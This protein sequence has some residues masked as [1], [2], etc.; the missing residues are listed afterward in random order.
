MP[1]AS[2]AARPAEPDSR[3]VWLSILGFWSFYFLVNSARGAVLAHHHQLAMLLPRVI[4]TVLSMAITAVFYLALR[5][6]SAASIRRSIVA[7][8][9]LAAPAAL[10]YSTVNWLVFDQQIRHEHAAGHSRPPRPVS[11]AGGEDSA[12]EAG[13]E[14][15]ESLEVGRMT[16]PPHLT[17]FQGIADQAVNGY[18][19]FVAWA[20]LHLALRYASEVRTLERRSADLRA[21]A[22]SAELRALRYQV[23]PHFLF[24]TLNSLSSLVLTD[25]R[26]R[27]ERMILNLS[28]FFRHSL[29]GD[30]TEDVT[31][32]EEI[33]LQRL[34]LD[35]EAVRFPER[36]RVAIDLPADLAAVKVPGMILQPLV[37]NAVKHAVSRTARPVTLRIAARRIA[38]D[39]HLEVSDDGDPASA[40]A[41]GTGVGLRNVCDRLTARFGE[42]AR[43]R[44]GR[45]DGGGYAVDITLP[46]TLDAG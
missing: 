37:E 19:F 38:D 10:A 17:P 29:T 1:A 46:M 32:A 8:A 15:G 35:I 20:A 23:N 5:G 39:L 44:W 42:R 16:R 25:K 14:Q 7:A 34:Y 11:R 6:S 3:G 2:R 4:V 12:S 41:P 43:C 9:V 27:A 30:P 33:D 22:Q 21:A 13:Q 18:F 24:N 36:L 28:T 40:G 26:D 31:L 45:R